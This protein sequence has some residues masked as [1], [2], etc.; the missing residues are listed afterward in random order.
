MHD[1][2]VVPCP[3]C[4][5]RVGYPEGAVKGRC[6]CGYDVVRERAWRDGG[7]IDPDDWSDDH[8]PGCG[9]CH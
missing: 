7:S 4:G 6:A 1:Y 5:R 8:L 3:Q 9:G 2:H